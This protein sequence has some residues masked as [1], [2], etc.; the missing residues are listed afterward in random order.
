MS[1]DPNPMGPIAHLK[2]IEREVKRQRTYERTADQPQAKVNEQPV[3][4][5]SWIARIA[6]IFAVPRTSN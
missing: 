3:A 1:F 6:D 2:Q 5:K 4:L